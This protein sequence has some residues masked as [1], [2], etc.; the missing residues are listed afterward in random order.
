[1]KRK[2][3]L[4][5]VCVLLAMLLA[6]PAYALEGEDSTNTQD[7]LAMTLP[8]A[9]QGSNLIVKATYTGQAEAQSHTDHAFAVDE[10]LYGKCEGETLNVCEYA[11]IAPH[12]TYT[13][14]QQY[15]LV[16][17]RG[18]SVYFEHDRILPSG[19]LF[20]PLGGEEKPSMW[21]ALPGTET[22]A[23]AKLV[24]DP[25]DQLAGILGRDAKLKEFEGIDY[26][27][28][29]DIAEITAGASHVMKVEVNKVFE[30]GVEPGQDYAPYNCTITTLYNGKASGTPAV[31]RFFNGT[32]EPGQE[33]VVLA[34]IIEQGL[35]GYDLAAKTNSVFALDAPELAE[36]E[37]QLNK[38]SFV[39]PAEPAALPFADVRDTDWFRAPVAQLYSAGLMNGVSATAFGGGQTIRR[40]DV[41][42]MLGRLAEKLGVEIPAPDCPS[43]FEDAYPDTYYMSYLLWAQQNGIVNGVGPAQFG[44]GQPVTRQ[45]FCTILDRFAA[46]LHRPMKDLSDSLFGFQDTA[47]IAGYARDAVAACLNGKVV[48]GYSDG[49]FKPASPIKRSEAAKMLA[50]FVELH[51]DAVEI[52]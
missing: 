7:L 12:L 14:G 49:T 30:A 45:D 28:S 37:E 36:V 24:Q 47:A 20:L 26:V 9:V 16:L 8:E 13:Q 23:L 33:Y 34:N 43:V 44:V 4:S 42:V 15:L 18:V 3:L 46:Y 52:K 19:G 48:N 27:R 50:A 10:V 21:Q 1:M 40:E 17:T 32:V 31:I 35:Q 6:V 39:F 38:T 51:L 29:D 11:D 22:D 41:V 25:E 2:K 5:V